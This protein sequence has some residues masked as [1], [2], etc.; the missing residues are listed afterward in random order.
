VLDGVN[1]QNSRYD[2][3]YTRV[4]CVITATKNTSNLRDLEHNQLLSPVSV[5]GKALKHE[6]IAGDPGNP[7]SRRL[8]GGTAIDLELVI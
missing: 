4:I 8:R 6:N 7:L 3:N 2:V 5:K 1:K